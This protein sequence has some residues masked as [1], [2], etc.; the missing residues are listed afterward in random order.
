M[1][2]KTKIF[3]G[4]GK[5]SVGK[6]QLIFIRMIVI[7]E[8][9]PSLLYCKNYRVKKVA[10][11]LGRI[12]EQILLELKAAFDSRLITKQLHTDHTFLGLDEYLQQHQ[13]FSLN[14]AYTASMSSCLI[15]KPREHLLKKRLVV[16]NKIEPPV[17]LNLF[18]F[19]IKTFP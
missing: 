2:G 1:S 16:L 9:P 17:L 6:F 3:L 18:F 8:T 19:F 14:N 11:T 12:R 15:C 7:N 10:A 4:N 13:N 5:L